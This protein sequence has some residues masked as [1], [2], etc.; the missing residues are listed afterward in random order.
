MSQELVNEL[1]NKL[2]LS[3]IER[4]C[5]P[6]LTGPLSEREQAYRCGFQVSAAAPEKLRQFY[7]KT[8]QIRYE[9]WQELIQASGSI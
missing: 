5:S 4:F 1:T 2:Q 3:W 9:D 6:E 8:W 7:F